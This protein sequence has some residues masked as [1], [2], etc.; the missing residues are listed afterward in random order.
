MNARGLAQGTA[1][2]ATP[3]S[4]SLEG[5]HVVLMICDG[6]RPDYVTEANMP[7]LAKLAKSGA[8]FTKHHPVYLSSTETNGT[9]IATGCWPSTSGI[10]A[11]SEYRPE[12][13]KKK[14]IRLD[15]T[16]VMVKDDEIT[17]GKHIGRDTIAEIIQKA[18][19]RT[20]IAGTKAVALLMDRKQITGG[21]KG[22]AAISVGKV[23]PADLQVQVD[24]AAG[25]PFPKEITYPNTTADAWTTKALLQGLW[26]DGV[27][28][29]SVLWMSDPDYSQHQKAPGSPEALASL[30]SVDDNLASVLAALEARG[31]REKT[32]IFLASD[33]GFS[34][35]STLLDTQKTLQDWGFA[36]KAQYV[37]DP[38]PGEIVIVDLGGTTFFYVV[39]HDKEVI[40]KLVTKLQGWEHAG[41]IF[42]KEALPGA[43]ALSDE[44]LDS[45]NAPDVAVS[46]KWSEAPGR[47]G[48]KGQIPCSMSKYPVDGGMHASLSRYDMHNTFIAAGPGI[49]PGFVGTIPSGNTDVAPTLLSLLGLHDAAAAMDGRILHEALRSGEGLPLPAVEAEKLLPL[50]LASP[51]KAWAPYLK[52]TTVGKA[53]YFDEGNNASEAG[54]QAARAE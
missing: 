22:S 10:L 29:L 38:R 35:I 16:D 52:A 53:V 45:V 19:G 30:K 17:G 23:Y 15:G 7:T 9:A 3:A 1:A 4:P 41:V 49:R 43:Y 13:D 39:G 47:F 12:I 2:P 5:K 31:V 18:G 36:A 11:N 51:V 6:L 42:T 25:G 34:S 24:A 37:L 14:G 33:H 44:K 28:T 54:P 32:H 27:P 48:M 40:Q 50:K 21:Q 46:F 8:T 26:K 20:A